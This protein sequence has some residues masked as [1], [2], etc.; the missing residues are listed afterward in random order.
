LDCYSVRGDFPELSRGITYLDNAA[1]T[2]K[3]V[4]VVEAMREFSYRSY[5]N[6]HRGV[7]RLSMEA[8][9]AYEDAHEAFAKFIGAGGWDEV[10]FVKNTSEAM[11]LVALTLYFNGYIGRGD[12]II[13]TMAEHHSTLLPWWRI[14]KMA[15]A[16]IKLLPLDSE[17]RPLW[18]RLDSMIT[19]R[20][21][22]VAFAHVS[23]VTG[24]V[25]PVREVA[26][27]AH[28]AGALVVLDAAQSAPHLRFNVRE[29]EVDFAAMSG[30][31]MLGPTGIGVL[32]GRRDL[33]EELEPPLG[34]GGT[35]IRSRLVGGEVRV[36]WEEPPWKFE[37]GTPPIIE[38]VGLAKAVEYL[39]KI[40]MDNVESHERRLTEVAM[41]LLS[42][43]EGLSFVGPSRP[44][45]RH[46]I[47]SFNVE[48]E[49]P[50]TLGL[51]LDSKKVA[52]RTG[53][54][55]AHIL[56]DHLG[57]PKG[58]VRASVYIYNCP[59]DLERLYEAL[60]EILGGP[61]A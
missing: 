30:H 54:H 53:L 38:A 49:D 8:S 59:E 46:G 7:H 11:Q 29:L 44:G 47:V 42:E 58:S 25:S 26:R 41:K 51:L 34:A 28:K 36:E 2:L 20:T 61:R 6:V 57:Y 4:S 24:Y 27:R 3:P 48:G 60:R 9:K 18:D 43:I 45:E 5:A 33:L 13:V 14:A 19:E 16:R 10:V 22:V 21:R 40:G 15:G 56:H 1:S 17:G 37:S 39:G 55:C 50:D 35:V 32:W 23:N 12:E 52:V 31:K